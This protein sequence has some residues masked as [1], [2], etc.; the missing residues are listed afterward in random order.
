MT[1]SIRQKIPAIVS[2]FANSY[3]GVLMLGVNTIQGATTQPVEGYPTPDREEL[4]LSIQNS[5]IENIDPPLFPRTRQIPSD[6]PGKSFLVVDVDASAEAPHAIENSRKVYV[7]TGDS[8]RPYDIAEIDVIERLIERRKSTAKRKNEMSNEGKAF[9][10]RYF[11][12]D[13]NPLLL[14]TITPPYPDAPIAERD[15]VYRF[16]S[17][18]SGYRGNAFRMPDGG[19]LVKSEERLSVSIWKWSVYGHLFTAN[20]MRYTNGGNVPGANS[21]LI[22]AGD[23]FPLSWIAGDIRKVFVEAADFFA[24]SK[25]QGPV[26]ITVT[27]KNVHGRSFTGGD[28]FLARKLDCIAND[29]PAMSVVNALD[30]RGIECI[31]DVFYQLIWPFF[32]DER[33]VTKEQTVEFV[34]RLMGQTLVR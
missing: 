1:D 30:L 26:E 22:R 6:V 23:V 20:M 33:F 32:S 8:S 7:R 4:S 5:C 34:R 27:L 21:E 17:G 25:F 24:F 13:T 2:S 15:E 29:V 11:N 3:G 31:S 16:L 12:F 9:A 10:S 18:I 19:C 14:M 28:N